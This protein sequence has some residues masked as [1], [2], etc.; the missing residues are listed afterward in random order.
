MAAEE[1]IMNRS[2]SFVKQMSDCLLKPSEK[3]TFDDFNSY[4]E[5]VSFF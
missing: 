1:E 3:E 2:F 4:K 5:P